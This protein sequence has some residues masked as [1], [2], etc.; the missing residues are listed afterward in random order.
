MHG[1]GGAIRIA[2]CMI[3]SVRVDGSAMR[4]NSGD[5]GSLVERVL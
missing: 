5:E 2:H 4:K 3:G 1:S